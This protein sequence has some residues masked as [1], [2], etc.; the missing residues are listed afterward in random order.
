MSVVQGKKITAYNLKTKSKDQPMKV[1]EIRMYKS[2]KEGGNPRYQFGGV[3]AKEGNSMSVYTNAETAKLASKALKIPITTAIAK[4]STKKSCKAKGE[5]VVKACE[6]KKAA[7]KVDAP[8][9]VAPKKDSTEKV[10]PKKVV[11][12]KEEDVLVAL[13]KKA[14]PKKAAPKKTVSKK[15]V[16]TKKAGSPVY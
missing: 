11:K 3:D 16:A 4:A 14:A 5:A 6:E 15:K 8:K 12:E 2:A 10:A 13:P 1:K 7:K 9:K